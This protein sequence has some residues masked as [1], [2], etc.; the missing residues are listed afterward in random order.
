MDPE[1]IRSY[2]YLGAQMS[3]LRDW[4]Y[5]KTGLYNERSEQE[6]ELTSCLLTGRAGR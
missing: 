6:Q 2:T 4:T 5:N 1:I 3:K